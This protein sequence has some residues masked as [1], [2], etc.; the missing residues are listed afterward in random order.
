[1]KLVLNGQG[2]EPSFGEQ[3]TGPALCCTALPTNSLRGKTRRRPPVRARLQ[4]FPAP[5][6]SV[7]FSGSQAEALKSVGMWMGA[8][9]NSSLVL[10][11]ILANGR[12]ARG[13]L[14]DP[15]LPPCV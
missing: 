1:M 5:Q 3:E 2:E 4:A 14:V 12:S 6:D 7:A 10:E 15:D 11:L 9:W 8:T 13:L